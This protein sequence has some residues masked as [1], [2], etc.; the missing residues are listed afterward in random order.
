MH[1]YSEKKLIFRNFELGKNE[2]KVYLTKILQEQKTL[3]LF[4]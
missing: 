1:N 2:L 4:P 3:K